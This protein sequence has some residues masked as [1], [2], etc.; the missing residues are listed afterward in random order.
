[1]DKWIWRWSEKGP[2]FGREIQESQGL[3][4]GEI[5]MFLSPSSRE[6][7]VKGPCYYILKMRKMSKPF[8]FLE[9]DGEYLETSGNPR[10]NISKLFPKDSNDSEEYYL[11]KGTRNTKKCL[12]NFTHDMW[13]NGWMNMK[14]IRKR[15]QIW[16]GDS[17]LS[18]LG[19]WR[20]PDVFR[21]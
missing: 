9:F 16:Q 3:D 20:N 13:I 19:F 14:M 15:S 2:K 1:M 6:S 11:P 12:W 7:A 18:G 4:S 8:E 5:R 21:P 10:E 17:G